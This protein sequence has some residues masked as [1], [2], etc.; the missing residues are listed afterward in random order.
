MARP[1]FYRISKCT[2]GRFD[3]DIVR[4]DDDSLSRR[5]LKNLAEVYAA[6]DDLRALMAVCG[7]TIKQ[8]PEQDGDT[9]LT[10]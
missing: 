6:L 4:A 9:A 8:A 1:V 3:I 5:G 10:A 7:A 2:D